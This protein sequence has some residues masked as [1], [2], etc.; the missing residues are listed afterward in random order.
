MLLHWLKIILK[1]LLPVSAK[2]KIRKLLL[3]LTGN[4]LP[5]TVRIEA[6]TLCQLNCSACYMRKS[7]YGSM[8]KGYL[9][10]FDFENFIQRNKFVKNIELSNSGEIFLNPDLIHIIKYAFENNVKLS[11]GNGVNFNTVSDEII[12]ALVKFCF[13][14]ISISIDA[15]SQQIYSLYRTNGNFNTVIENIKKLNECKQKYNSKFPELTWQYIIMEHNEEDVIKAKKMAEQLGMRISFKL[16]WDDYVSQNKDMLIKETGLKCL[17]HKELFEAKKIIPNSNCY[18][19]WSSPQINWDG[20]LLGCC[21]V[22]KDDFGVNVFDIGLKKAINS[23][24]YKSAKKMLLGKVDV[25][26][27]TQNIP[28]IICE[29]YQTMKETGIYV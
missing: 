19:L 14:H 17:S 13:R 25:I 12:E 21:V 4:R 24:N 8:G 28:C 9:K 22:Y 27:N 6:S 10:F 7:N 5:T 23:E 18:G 20:R 26:Q 29:Q 1:H 2:A 15:A 11:A 16:P 3:R